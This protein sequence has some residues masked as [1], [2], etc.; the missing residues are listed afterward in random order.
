MTTNRNDHD[1]THHG[2]VRALNVLAMVLTLLVIP[3]GFI[4][5]PAT[6]FPLSSMVIDSGPP[7]PPPVSAVP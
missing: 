6:L 2:L 4:N 1:L 7:A 3:Y 5:P